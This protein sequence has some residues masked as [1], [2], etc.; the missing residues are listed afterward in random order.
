MP[1]LCSALMFP[2]GATLAQRRWGLDISPGVLNLL[3]LIAAVWCVAIIVAY[4]KQE[5]ALSALIGKIQMAGLAV[6]GTG[7][8]LWGLALLASGT[9]PAWLAVKIALF[10]MVYYLAMGINVTFR[11]VIQQL[12]VLPADGGDDRQEAALRSAINVCCAV[13]LGLY[14]VIVASSALGTMRFPG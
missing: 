14:A 7:A 10:G 11:P 12:V 13:V 1:R 2:V 4:R 9:V 6:A 8:T 3:W 5:S